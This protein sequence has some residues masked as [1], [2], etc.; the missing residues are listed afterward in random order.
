MKDSNKKKK[1]VLIGPVYPYKGGIAHYTSLL[2]K[3]LSTEMETIMISFNLQYPAF[4]YKKEQ[5]DYENDVFKIQEAQYL[6]NT[7]NPFNWIRVAKNIIKMQPNAVIIQWWHPYFTPCFGIISKI[8]RNNNVIFICHNIL[9]HERFFLDKVLTKLVLKNGKHCIV[10]SKSDKDNLQEILPEANIIQTVHP[11]Y[12]AFKIN[13]ISKNEARHILNLNEHDNILLF[14]GFIREYKGLSY[15]IN[16]L[17][18]IVK[19]LNN[20]KLLIVGDFKDSESKQSYMEM[21]MRLG[22]EEYI[23]VY[24]GYIPDNEVEKFFAACDL[25]VLPYTSATQSG[26]VQIAYGF[27]KPVVVTNVG[28][29]P[30][31][32]EQGKT[33]YVVKPC[34]SNEIA[35]VINEYFVSGN[36]EDIVESI[37]NE[38][39]KYSWKRMRNLIDG[40][41]STY[42]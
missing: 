22:M 21:I 37:K 20:T 30:D 41:S 25:V 38:E 23:E 2:C 36:E 12:N 33:G 31:V 14:F 28:G 1:V 15:L 8:L 19:D 35:K 32:V 16:A 42:V 5:K 27:E 29:L 24:D 39:F 13:N 6:I 18:N 4:L 26:I 11:T 9:P 10:H 3:E 34:S 17:P 7:I 40:I